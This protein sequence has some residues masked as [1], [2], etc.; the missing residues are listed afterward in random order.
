MMK[1]L[2]TT[3]LAG[4]VLALATTAAAQRRIEDLP[5][6]ERLGGVL[7]AR[8]LGIDPGLVFD[9]RIRYNQ[10]VYDL[11]PVYSMHRHS[12]RDIE[13]IWR[14]RSSGMGWGQIA[15]EIG[16]HPGTFNQLRNQGAFD[17]DRIWHT[18][19]TSRYG[20][21]AEQIRRLQGMGFGP[22]AIAAIAHISFRSGASIDQVAQAFRATRNWD[23]IPRQFGIEDDW[24]DGR[25]RGEWTRAPGRA[26]APGQNR[27]Q[28]QGQGKGQGK[29]KG[30]G[31]G[32]GGG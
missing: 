9:T 31:K 19:Y 11:A 29:G 1:G 3:L 18:T 14:L 8:Q 15:Q 28:G 32:K 27:G 23:T 4:L 10:S 16:M 12:R 26:T 6:H 30:K 21:T 24:R 25:W 17:R 20:L 5:W 22:D 13:H 2:K 7:I